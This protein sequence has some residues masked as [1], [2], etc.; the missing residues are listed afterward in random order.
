MKDE[1][2]I[3]LLILDAAQPAFYLLSV[4]GKKLLGIYHVSRERGGGTSE[5]SGINQLNLAFF[6]ELPPPVL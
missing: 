6:R 4:G 1:P 5:T 3:F 2:I